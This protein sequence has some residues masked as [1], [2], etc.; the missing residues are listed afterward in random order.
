MFYSHSYS[1]STLGG[2]TSLSC[3]YTVTTPRTTLNVL[4]PSVL[5]LGISRVLSKQGV[6]VK[7]KYVMKR[8]PFYP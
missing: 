7:L 6:V 4:G 2:P 8:L 5:Q 3:G 1:P